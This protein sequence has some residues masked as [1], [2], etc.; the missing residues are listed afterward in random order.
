[1]T[2]KYEYIKVAIPDSVD[3]TIQILNEYGSTGWGMTVMY[4]GF[5]FF[6]RRTKVKIK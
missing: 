1:M 4:N 2:I 5:I 3:E 6:E